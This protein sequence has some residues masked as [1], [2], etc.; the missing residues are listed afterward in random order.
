MD[1]NEKSKT[2]GTISAG[3][4][5]ASSPISSGAQE[6][7]FSLEHLRD[8]SLAVFG[9]TQST[10]DGATYG[11]KGEFTVSALKEKIK[12]WQNTQILPSDKKGEN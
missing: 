3:Q 10:F 11:L 2:D 9:I 1:K 8:D 12:A 6:P 7:L 4:T 5:K